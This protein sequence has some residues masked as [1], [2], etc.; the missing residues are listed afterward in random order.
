MAAPPATHTELVT[1]LIRENLGP[2]DEFA[3]ALDGAFRAAGLTAG[4]KTT[5]KLTVVFYHRSRTLPGMARFGVRACT[6]MR[7]VVLS[8][9]PPSK[10][11]SHHWSLSDSF[12]AG[13]RDPIPRVAALGPPGPR[14][15][16]THDA[17]RPAGGG[18]GAAHWGLASPKL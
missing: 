13:A 8:R 15:A 1:W 2:A 4:A 5:E 18:G 9:R 10:N 14:A 7:H 17:R 12:T 11:S 3:I 6:N 16:G